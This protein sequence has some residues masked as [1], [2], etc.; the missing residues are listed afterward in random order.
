MKAFKD[1]VVL[2][3]LLFIIVLGIKS[4]MYMRHCTIVSIFPARRKLS[5][6]WFRHC[7]MY[8]HITWHHTSMHAFKSRIYSL[9]FFNQKVYTNVFN[10]KSVKIQR[11]APQFP[12]WRAAVTVWKSVETYR[13][14][15]WLIL[16][17]DIFLF[18]SMFCNKVHNF[19]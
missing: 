9:K 10:N 4:G 5:W 12:F 13:L 3:L 17:C 18:A 11:E 7:T 16:I 15:V 19:F 6:L 8:A 1:Y 2:L 14:W